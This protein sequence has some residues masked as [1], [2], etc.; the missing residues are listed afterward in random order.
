MPDPG[1]HSAFCFSPGDLESNATGFLT[2][3]QRILLVNHIKGEGCGRK[4]ALIAM[5]LTLLVLAGAFVLIADPGSPGFKQAMPYYIGTCALF[6]L[7]FV[8]FLLLHRVRTRDIRS[9]LI[10][11]V[12]GELRTWKK[13]YSTGTAFYAEVGG[14]KFQLHSSEQMDVLLRHSFYRIYY[15]S[16]PPVHIILS[17]AATG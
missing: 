11:S 4:A 9:G 12:E 2:Q 7:I 5:G 3:R 17:L 15:I 13:E 10:S 6:V 16:N 8:F 14:T 1:I